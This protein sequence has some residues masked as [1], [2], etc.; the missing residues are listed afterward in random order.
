VFLH[1]Y[2]AARGGAELGFPV[3]LERGRLEFPREL[4][5]QAR[6]EAYHGGGRYVGTFH[7][8]PPGRESTSAPFFDPQDLASALRSDNAG[9][10]ELLLARDRL[11]AL[12]RANPYLYISAHHVTRNPLLLAEEHRRRLRRN[13]GAALDD[14]CYPEQYRAASL[15]WF[16]RYGL[17]LYEG[18]PDEALRRVFTPSESWQ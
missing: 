11:F 15:Y 9:F 4:A 5:A 6:Y 18:R 17:A 2:H 16:R 8:H 13:G 7:V 1:T 12:V 3:V 14:P 10:I